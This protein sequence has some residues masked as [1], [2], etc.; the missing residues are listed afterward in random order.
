ML[1]K[2]KINVVFSNNNC[3]KNKLIKNTPIKLSGC[4]YRIPCK[5]CHK[6][7]VGQT[8]K[9]IS[10]RIVQHKN[11]VRRG[12]NSN[13]IFCHIENDNHTIN[14][15]NSKIIIKCNS[16]MLR[17]IFES[18][19]INYTFDNN[20]NISCGLYKEDELISELIVRY[21]KF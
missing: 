2:F 13:S 18:V 5:D 17:N 19:L 4:V 16:W 6:Y 7:Y 3:L 8:G 11:C 10:Q 20:L 9:D 1:R 15:N 21:Y 12:D 14:W